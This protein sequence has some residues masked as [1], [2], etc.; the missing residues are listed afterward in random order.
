MIIA[1]T[2]AALYV[3]SIY[4][5]KDDPAER[6]SVNICMFIFISSSSRSH[7][8]VK[9]VLLYLCVRVCVFVGT[10]W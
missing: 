1:V 2:A 9:F 5:A 8:Q 3:R 10:F 6:C 7:D 4:H